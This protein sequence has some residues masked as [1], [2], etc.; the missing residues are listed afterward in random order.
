MKIPF[1]SRFIEKRQSILQ[2]RLRDW[3][4][5]MDL[6]CGPPSSAGVAVSEYTALQ[7]TAVYACVRILAETVASLPLPLYR[8][9]DRGKEKAL[10]HPLYSLLHDLPNPDMTGFTFR[11]TLISIDRGDI[12]QM[13][14]GFVVLADK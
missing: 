13:S 8:R 2:E 14:F 12:S 4:L 6:N 7:A 11:E 1:V 10:K 3:L 9:L 5:V